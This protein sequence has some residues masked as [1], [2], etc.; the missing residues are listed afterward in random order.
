MHCDLPPRGEARRQDHPPTAGAPVPAGTDHEPGQDGLVQRRPAVPVQ[1]WDGCAQ[2][3]E[4]AGARG[5]A[6]EAD[7]QEGAGL[8]PHLPRQGGQ[9]GAGR[10]DGNQDP[11]RPRQHHGAQGSG[12]LADLSLGR[13]GWWLCG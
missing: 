2:G 7:A 8:A 13:G 12:R 4:A 6:G 1:L 10:G 9:A 3:S 5:L 11:A